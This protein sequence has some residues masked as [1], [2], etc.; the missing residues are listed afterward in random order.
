MADLRKGQ[1]WEFRARAGE[2]HALVKIQQV[3]L[4]SDDGEE[5]FHVS[6]IGLRCRHGTELPHV[7]VYRQALLTSITR[8][9]KKHGQFPDHIPGLEAWKKAE[10][11]VYSIP[12][13]DIIEI[14][15]FDAL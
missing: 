1:V 7:P 14:G 6:M 15:D 2:D 13:A 3:D 10:G 5:I 11:G 12:L 9:V 8:L 4:S